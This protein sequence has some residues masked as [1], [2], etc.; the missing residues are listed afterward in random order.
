MK[1][2]WRTKS[3]RERCAGLSKVAEDC[4][5][6]INKKGM[7]GTYTNYFLLAYEHLFVFRKPEM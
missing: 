1:Y 3:T 6:D 2:Q 5:V 4:W 7:K